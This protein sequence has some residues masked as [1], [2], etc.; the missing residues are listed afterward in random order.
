MHAQGSNVFMSSK[1]EGGK[2]PRTARLQEPKPVWAE[3]LKRMYDSVV[4]EEVP[5]EIVALLK[6]LDRASDPN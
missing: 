2:P 1:P 4:G 5:D 6:K 3:G